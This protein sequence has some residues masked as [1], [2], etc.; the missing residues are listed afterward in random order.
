MTPN[1]LPQSDLSLLLPR[2]I[3]NEL[4]PAEFETLEQLLD[5]DPHARA[6]YRHHISVHAML[7]WRLHR[8]DGEPS[9]RTADAASDLHGMLD[10]DSD[11][12]L[13]SGKDSS[14]QPS[15]DET[16]PLFISSHHNYG[17]AGYLSSA[18]LM[19]YLLAAFFVG[20]GLSILAVVPVAPP[21]QIVSHPHPFDTL[22]SST[23]PMQSVVGQITGIVDCVWE[24]SEVKGQGSGENGQKA[25]KSSVAIGDRLAIS[26]GLLEITY[27][28]GAKVIL[29]G[30]VTYEVESKNGG[31]MLVGKLTGKVTTEA[32][33]GLTIRT[34]TAIVTD[35][36]TEFG[37][38]VPK[39]GDTVVHVFEGKVDCRSLTRRGE[40]SE[41]RHLTA[42]QTA[43]VVAGKVAVGPQAA[44]T[45][46]FVRTIATLCSTSTE[47]PRSR[48]LA[49]WRFEE[50]VP[51]GNPDLKQPHAK[52]GMVGDV[53]QEKVI[54]DWSGHGNDLNYNPCNVQWELGIGDYVASNDVPP[55]SMFRPGYSGGKKSFN[56]GALD[57]HKDGVLFHSALQHGNVF[58]FQDGFTMEGYFKTDGDQSS[59]GVMALVFK[60]AAGP[61]Y[62]VNLNRQSPGAVQF[63]LFDAPG[64]TVSVTAADRNFADGQWRY[65]AARFDTTQRSATLL[66]I[67]AN[68]QVHRHSTRVPGDFVLNWP[69]ND[70]LIGRLQHRP[71]NVQG[72]FR[73]R[74]DEVRI[75]RGPLG[76]EQLLCPPQAP[77]DEGS[78]GK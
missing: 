59:V 53:L 69:N 42:G 49:Y 62:L 78:N 32:A 58:D 61:V 66:L 63:T 1:N 67:A 70:L 68:G 26:S 44:S 33:R 77:Q 10:E 12:S 74:I 29:Q 72:H 14:P 13:H 11:E 54:R 51:P 48:V 27:N 15:N 16:P 30:P 23:S 71:G 17:T 76:D 47:V 45:P 18:W 41:T 35:L 75:C 5:A 4:T 8:Q 3:E 37:V 22:P 2:F 31:F 52:R 39:H 7:Y 56:S 21:A 65:F 50:T 38:E 60:G 46:E 64:R 24:G 6:I 57:P 28:T 43:R 36:G 40:A 55:S 20:I 73:G 9:N 19:A 25:M 34:P